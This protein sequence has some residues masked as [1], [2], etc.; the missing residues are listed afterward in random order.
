M[1]RT[2]IEPVTSDGFR[3]WRSSEHGWLEL[4]VPADE[5]GVAPALDDQFLTATALYNLAAVEGSGKPVPL[6]CLPEA[7]I[8][9]A[10]R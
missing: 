8:G 7:D 3:G 9:S 5:R 2:G 1:E 4:R 6:P 10:V